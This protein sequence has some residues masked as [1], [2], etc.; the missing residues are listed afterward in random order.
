MKREE[1]D[2]QRIRI[3]RGAPGEDWRNLTHDAI[4]PMLARGTGSIAAETARGF[5]SNEHRVT[6]ENCALAAVVA[7]LRRSWKWIR[8]EDRVNGFDLHWGARFKAVRK[9]KRLG[10]R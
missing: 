10:Q 8:K 9:R 7:E 3:E 6:L 2:P 1:L 4:A 5:D